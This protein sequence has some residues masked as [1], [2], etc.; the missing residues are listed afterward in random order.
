MEDK[1]PAHEK[2]KRNE[3]E[4]LVGEEGT[5]LRGEKDRGGRE[6]AGDGSTNRSVKAFLLGNLGNA[7]NWKP[8][9]KSMR[10]RI[11]KKKR[12]GFLSGAP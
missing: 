4:R 8:R 5:P 10:E 9:G 6:A 1:G 11:G 3:S 2:T 7:E 12:K